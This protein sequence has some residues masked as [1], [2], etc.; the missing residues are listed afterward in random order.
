MGWIGHITDAGLSLVAN[1]GKRSEITFTRAEGGTGSYSD[2]EIKSKIELF[3]VKQKVN[4]TASKKEGAK[5]SIKLEIAAANEKY[6]L[7]QIGLYASLDSE[8]D[9]LF[10]IFQN[11]DG[12]NILSKQDSPLFVYSFFGTLNF[13]NLGDININVDND[14]IVT[15]ETLKLYLSQVVKFKDIWPNELESKKLAV[16]TIYRT[17]GYRDM[18]GERVAPFNDAII[19]GGWG[20]EGTLADGIRERGT[21]PQFAFATDGKIYIRTHTFDEINR[22]DT[23]SEWR[24]I[25]ADGGIIKE[26]VEA[27]IASHSHKEACY[28]EVLDVDLTKCAVI[29][30][31]DESTTLFEKGLAS[32]GAIA[33]VNISGY[34]EMSA[35]TDN[36]GAIYLKKKGESIYTE[37]ILLR[38]DSRYFTFSGYIDAMRISTTYGKLSFLKLTVSE[39]ESTSGFMTP[40]MLKMLNDLSENTYT[41]DKSKAL[42]G[43]HSFFLEKHIYLD[44]NEFEKAQFGDDYWISTESSIYVSKITNND[45]VEF[46]KE[47]AYSG[48]QFFGYVGVKKLA[49][50]SGVS[51]MLVAEVDI[52]TELDID[53]IAVSGFYRPNG[54]TGADDKSLNVIIGKLKQGKNYILYPFT[55]SDHDIDGFYMDS[56]TSGTN[57]VKFTLHDVRLF[58]RTE[59]TSEDVTGLKDWK[60]EITQNGNTIFSE[61]GEY[62]LYKDSKGLGAYSLS[63]SQGE[64]LQA[65]ILLYRPLEEV[66]AKKEEIPK[67]PEIPKVDQN[68]SATSKNA[69]SGVAVAQAV[70]EV[71]KMF[72]AKTVTY[73]WH[74]TGK[75]VNLKKGA[76]YLIMANDKS[77]RVYDE[78]GSLVSDTGGDQLPSFTSGI[79]L[80]TA[81]D[82]DNTK[83]YMNY[84]V[85]ME[86]GSLIPSFT[87]KNFRLYRT[88]EDTGVMP[89]V[90]SES[91]SLN[92]YELYLG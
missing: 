24:A 28:S 69:Q 5:Y 9:V 71:K 37:N 6:T 80:T 72:N 51:Y 32:A 21:V 81:N 20:N 52:E 50:T 61:I 70:E 82:L 4:I 83:L 84:F 25:S 23:R 91:S 29:S 7:N 42:L 88:K 30:S 39:K 65:D 44:C 18:F 15:L 57:A 12:V 54:G 2:E 36:I 49:V 17:D 58:A 16:N 22:I 86:K 34:V 43:A 74:D 67:I 89:Y 59:V 46:G 79:F 41:K 31:G 90:L 26:E 60:C 66:F 35:Y 48:T 77:A 53:N 1:W 33:D 19:F 40:K 63:Y 38:S 45:D 87:T 27:L 55:A 56:H 62:I 76:L 13:A 64:R 8:S 85:S 75:K 47:L 73:Y 78:N 68:Y 92:V 3:S 10:A 14:F 11:T